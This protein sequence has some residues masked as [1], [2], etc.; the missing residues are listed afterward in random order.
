MDY[1]D[2]GVAESDTT[3]RLSLSIIKNFVYCLYTLKYSSHK[4]GRI[5]A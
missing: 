4:K 3:E 2:H 1:I 5:N